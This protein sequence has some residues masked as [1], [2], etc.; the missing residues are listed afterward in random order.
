MLSE[1]NQSWYNLH[2]EGLCPPREKRIKP[3]GYPYSH[4]T[5]WQSITGLELAGFHRHDKMDVKPT[6]LGAG[7]ALAKS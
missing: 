4:P 7:E 2:Q 1:P 3:C 5:N 6:Q